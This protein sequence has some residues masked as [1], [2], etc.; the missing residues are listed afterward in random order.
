MNLFL[1]ASEKPVNYAIAN[2]VEE[3]EIASLICTIIIGSRLISLRS[4]PSDALPTTWCL[5]GLEDNSC[6]VLTI[7]HIVYRYQ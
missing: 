2:T 5:A 7:G 4:T 1:K 6:R 3:V